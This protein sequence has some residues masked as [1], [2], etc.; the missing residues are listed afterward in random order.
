[1][2]GRNALRNGLIAVSL[3]ALP[4]TTYGLTAFADSPNRAESG[5]H[6]QFAKGEKCDQ[7]EHKKHGKHH[8]KM[9]GRHG[10]ALGQLTFY[11]L[12]NQMV[13]SV[14][15][16]TNQP[17][18]AV[19]STLEDEGMRGLMKTYD[20]SREALATEMAPK[21]SALVRTA[22]KDGRLTDLQA[23]A[24]IAEIED[25]AAN[26]GMGGGEMRGEMRGEKHGDMHGGMRGGPLGAVAFMQTQNLTVDTLAELS[27]KSPSDVRLV[28]SELGPRLAMKNLGVDREAFSTA[29]K[30]KV[31]AVID[32]SLA[33]GAITPD[34]AKAL[35][36]QMNKEKGQRQDDRG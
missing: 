28:V 9:G 16:L 4:L 11:E 14:A 21:L 22:Q 33:E 23:D 35:T 30:T 7:G 17:A 26:P 19:R 5:Q 32:A 1:M 12:Q 27:G 13:T 3:A 25:R 31:Q 2:T 8:A 34:Q 29:F 10:G 20:L 24:L 36:D 6:L 15:A 18:D